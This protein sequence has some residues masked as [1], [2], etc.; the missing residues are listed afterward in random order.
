MKPL[1]LSGSV[2]L[3]LFNYLSEVNR[4]NR[5]ILEEADRSAL[6]TYPV[7][8]ERE[9]DTVNDYFADRRI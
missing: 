3:A 5:F 6:L 4:T 1:K 8:T 9:Q 2:E 7:R